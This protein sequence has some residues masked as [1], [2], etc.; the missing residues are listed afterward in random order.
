M[1]SVGR[2]AARAAVWAFLSTAGANAI[3]FAGLALLARLLTPAEFGLLAF[4]LVYIIYAEMIGDLGSGMALIYWPDRREDAAQVTFVVSIATGLFWCVTT[5]LLAPAIAG[6][7]NAANGAPIV[8]VLAA[9]FIIKCLG[10]THDALAQKDLRF[11][12]RVLPDLS[13]ALVN[14]AVALTLAW[15]GWGVWSLVWGRLAGVFAR[16]LLLW[17][18]VPWRPSRRLPTDL[19]NPMLRYGRGILAVNIL[20][21]VMLSADLAIVGRFLGAVALGL[22]QM[23]SRIPEATVMMLLW[24]LSRVVFPLFAKLH[25]GGED[26]RRPYLM[27]TRYIS[28]ITIPAAIGLSVLSGPI[29]SFFF[30]ERWLAAAPILSALAVVAALRCLSAHA[31]DVL[32]ATGRSKLLVRLSIVKVLLILPALLVGAQ[33]NA[34][35]VAMALAAATAAGALITLV[36]ASRVLGISFRDIAASFYPSIGAGAV[37]AMVLVLWVRWTPNVL[38][39]GQVAGGVGIGAL[40]YIAI[41]S[42]FDRT[43]LQGARRHLTGRG[44]VDEMLRQAAH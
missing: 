16:T 24:V 3:T 35:S 41:L 8:R 43:V 10:N 44:R 33:Y 34:V 4:A 13:L 31:G 30:G 36:V 28:A 26:L 29:V 22:Y 38:A 32:N 7:F 21:T 40:T 42:L 20:G 23:A 17:L 14:I 18:A 2:A 15:W 39:V 9:G 27:A 5:I 25:A 1:T 6:F 11:H 37:M 12:A 19:M